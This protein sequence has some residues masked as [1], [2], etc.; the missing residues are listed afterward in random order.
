MS[1]RECRILRN[2]HIRE[3][4]VRWCERSENKVG[5]I[6]IC[7]ITK[8]REG[9]HLGSNIGVADGCDDSLHRKG[10]ENYQLIQLDYFIMPSLF[11][12]L[13]MGI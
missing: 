7:K 6:E 11:L 9:V 8:S 4:Y 10:L 1:V 13:D 12:I 5:G 2:R 3:P